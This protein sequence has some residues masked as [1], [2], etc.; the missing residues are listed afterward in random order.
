MGVGVLSVYHIHIYSPHHTHTHILVSVLSLFISLYLI[1][2]PLLG[3][4]GGVCEGTG[5]G[6]IENNDV[7][8]Y[9]LRADDVRT[10]RQKLHVIED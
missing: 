1:F 7:N 8:H 4:D 3:T 10:K 2:M 5:P 6:T 9:C